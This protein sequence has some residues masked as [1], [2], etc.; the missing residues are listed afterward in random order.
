[1]SLFTRIWKRVRSLPT[2]PAWIRRLVTAL[3]VALGTIFIVSGMMKVLDARSFMETLPLYNLPEW[4][5]PLGSLAPAV[6][7]TLGAA[8]VLGIV[9]RLM[10]LATL[11]LLV[12]FCVLLVMGIAGGQLSDCGCFG[13]ALE[14]SPQSALL[15]N[16]VLLLLTGAVWNHYRGYRTVWRTWQVVTV[17]VV[18]LVA[19]LGTGYTVHSPRLDPS[20]AKVGDLFPDEGFGRLAPELSGRQLVYVFEADCSDCWNHVANLKALATDTNYTVFGLTDSD[21]HEIEWFANE[22]D[23]NF[24]VYTY[25]PDLFY[26]TFRT[27]PTLYYLEGSLILGKLDNQVPAP[28]ALEEVYLPEWR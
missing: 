19:G 21:P 10:T 1:M 9:P 20:L 27:W 3:R 15:R 11:A 25:N 13:Q 23:I 28:Q 5:I 12:V 2:F 26:T 7:V 22:F 16:L 4:L 18:M 17:A 24:T 6:E 14:Q 8:L